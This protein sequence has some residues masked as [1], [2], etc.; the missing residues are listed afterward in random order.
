MEPA[1]TAVL[2]AVRRLPGGTTSDSRCLRE[3]KRMGLKTG[4][5]GGSQGIDGKVCSME[6]KN[7]E[8]A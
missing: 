5:L 2:P 7:D 4:Q 1:A 3:G 8:E 6:E